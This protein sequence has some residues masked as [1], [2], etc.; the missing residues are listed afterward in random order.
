MEKSQLVPSQMPEMERS[1]AIKLDVVYNEDGERKLNLLITNKLVN[2]YSAIIDLQNLGKAIEPSA[3]FSPLGG[4][5]GEVGY[6]VKGI[7][8][9]LVGGGEAQVRQ[10]RTNLQLKLE[11]VRYPTFVRISGKAERDG[12]KMTTSTTFNLVD[13]GDGTVLVM[14]SSKE[15][16]TSFCTQWTRFLCFCP[17]LIV[18]LI[19][20]LPCMYCSYECQVSSLTSRVKQDLKDY[21]N[22]A[23]VETTSFYASK[24]AT[25]AIATPAVA[26]VPAQNDMSAQ[27]ENLKRLHEQGVLSDEEFKTAKMKVIQG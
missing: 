12:V 6:T 19:I 20:L 17:C 27:L 8:M 2:V 1:A 18:H 23:K 16:G 11:E 21:L 24:L 13:R 26:V 9:T 10:V 4:E 14:I 7:L 5:A 22:V 25:V 15:D 3:Q